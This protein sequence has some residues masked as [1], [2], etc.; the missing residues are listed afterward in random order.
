MA[1][2]IEHM[3]TVLKIGFLN[4]KVRTFIGTQVQ[5]EDQRE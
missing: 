2:G 5:T 3:A 4:E 1:E